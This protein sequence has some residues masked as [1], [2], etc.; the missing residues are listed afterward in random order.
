MLK[1]KFVGLASETSGENNGFLT[2]VAQNNR[3]IGETSFSKSQHL[4]R[5][6]HGGPRH[7][8]FEIWSKQKYS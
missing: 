4:R 1:H 3:L 6:K 5:K 7:F 8:K 2:I